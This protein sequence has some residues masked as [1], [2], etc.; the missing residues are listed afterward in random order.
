MARGELESLFERFRD[1]GDLAALA[2]VFDRTAPQLLSVARHLASAE[3]AAEDL[4]QATFVA[5]IEHAQRFEANRE[6]V[7][8]MV[9]ILTNKAKLA[10]ALA[11]RETDVVRLEQRGERDPALDAELSEFVATLNRALEVVPSRYRD[12]LRMHLGDGRTPEQI[13]R[14]LGREKGTVRV[15]LHRALAHLRRVLPPG[16]ALGAAVWLGSPRG[17][18]AVRSNVLRHARGSL[19]GSGSIVL[20]GWIVSTKAS[21]VVGVVVVALLGF[22]QWS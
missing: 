20:G 17:L 19:A 5:A 16:F 4:V 22:W 6:L 8:W 15:Q 7:P 11:A 14:E 12:L 10:R 13:A 1:R 21:V 2:R 9:G 18:A 3:A